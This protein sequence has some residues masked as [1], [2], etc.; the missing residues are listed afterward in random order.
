M[1][2]PSPELDRSPAVAPRTT[3][4]PPAEW[5]AAPEGAPAP[6]QEGVLDGMR[7]LWIVAL[8]FACG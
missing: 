4:A 8:T 6:R 2:H 3:Y 1:A 5:R 7:R